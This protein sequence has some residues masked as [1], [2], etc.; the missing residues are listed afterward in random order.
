VKKKGEKQFGGGVKDPE[1]GHAICDEKSFHLE[2][3]ILKMIIEK[4]IQ[5]YV[6]EESHKTQKLCKKKKDNP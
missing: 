1:D 3:F 2:S 5:V 6:Y 4:N